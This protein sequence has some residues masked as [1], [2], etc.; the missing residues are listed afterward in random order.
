MEALRDENLAENAANMGKLMRS[1][2]REIKSDSIAAVRGRGLLNAIVVRPTTSGPD[3]L[4]LCLALKNAGLLAKPT[5]NHI[6][7]LAPPLVITAEQV[8]E[9]TSI[10][11]NEVIKIFG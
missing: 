4:D 10:I 6:I 2:L 8:D 11:K 1:Q 3:A 9:A 5:H 7:R